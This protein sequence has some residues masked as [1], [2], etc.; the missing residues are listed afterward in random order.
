MATK[1][2]DEK[3]KVATK[4]ETKKP[5]KKAETK[6]ATKDVKKAVKNTKKADKKVVSKKVVKETPKKKEVKKVAPK[7]EVT[8]KTSTKKVVKETP[9][10]EVKPKAKKEDKKEVKETK[11]T[12]KK[13]N[14]EVKE[15]KEE[16]VKEEPVFFDYEKYANYAIADLRK[17]IVKAKKKGIIIKQSDINK[18]LEDFEEEKDTM[19]FLKFL[20]KN[21]IE[22]FDDEEKSDI[23]RQMSSNGAGDDDSFNPVSMYLKESYNPKFTKEEELELFRRISKGDQQALDTIYNANRL[24]AFKCAKDIYKNNKNLPLENLIAA[25]NFGL[26]KA[27]EKFDYKKENKLS[28]YATYWIN[29]SIR[30]TLSDKGRLVRIPVHMGDKISKMKK[31]NRLLTQELGRQPTDEEIAQR[32]NKDEKEKLK[33]NGKKGK[34]DYYNADKIKELRNYSHQIQSLD[35]KVNNGSDDDESSQIDFVEQAGELTPVDY[36]RQENSKKA[37]NDMLHNLLSDKEEQII[38][39]RWGL[40]EDDEKKY[41]LDEVGNLMGLTRERIRQIEGKALKK[42]KSPKNIKLLQS[43]NKQ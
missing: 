18:I 26:I 13:A 28:T 9:K 21:K 36:D 41:T 10:K 43:L 42:L 5:A 16:V 6:K 34:P 38:R 27:I 32:M 3:K 39:Y 31:A 35:K 4:K 1:R 30:R 19:K 8:K 14:K 33:R 40:F 2:K 12:S 11:K 25:G 23:Y 7:K 37:V 15:K 24:L 22:T 20:D 17:E 29:Q